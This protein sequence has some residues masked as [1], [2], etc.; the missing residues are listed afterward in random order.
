ML[1][2]VGKPVAKLDSCISCLRRFTFP[3]G[4]YSRNYYHS[5]RDIPERLFSPKRDVFTAVE[6][7]LEALSRNR[8][9]AYTADILRYTLEDRANFSD[10]KR[11]TILTK[12]SIVRTYIVLR[13][14]ERAANFTANYW[15]FSGGRELLYLTP[16][17]SRRLS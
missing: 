11:R 10:D 6:S 1:G 13:E 12:R 8:A 7:A 14:R 5:R 16:G 9:D 4:F 3:A 2:A 17:D 15:R